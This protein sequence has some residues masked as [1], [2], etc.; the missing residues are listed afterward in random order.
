MKQ[1]SQEYQDYIASDAWRRRR[2]LKL[3]LA[4]GLCG[5]VE[6]ELCKIAR[7][8]NRVDVHH[9]TYE[10]FGAERMDDLSILCRNCHDMVDEIESVVFGGPV[11]GISDALLQTLTFIDRRLSP[12]SSASPIPSGPLCLP[13]GGDTSIDDVVAIIQ[14]KRRELGIKTS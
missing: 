8:V 3:L 12:D 13:D 5:R 2:A 7:P 1:L 10:R 6:C 14:R 11:D 4:G 9:V